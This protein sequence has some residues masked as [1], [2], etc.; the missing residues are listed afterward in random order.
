M[1]KAGRDALERGFDGAISLEFHGARISSDTALFP[2]PDVD[3]ASG[4]TE[5]G[6]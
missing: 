5:C 4:P 1:A 6:I 2:Y 3:A